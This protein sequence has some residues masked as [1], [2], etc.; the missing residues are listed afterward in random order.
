[1]V[2]SWLGPDQDL[3][4]AWTHGLHTTWSAPGVAAAV[5]S[6]QVRSNPA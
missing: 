3:L 6:Y 4:L 1:M 2:L 5:A